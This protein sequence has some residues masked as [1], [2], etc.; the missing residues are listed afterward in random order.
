MI[1]LEAAR[2]R[3]LRVIC[4]AHAVRVAVADG[5]G[6][7]IRQPISAPIDLPPFDNS[8]MDGYA[9]LANDVR[10][11]SPSQPVRLRLRDRVPAGELPHAPV[12][13]GTCARV[14]TGSPLPPGADAVVMQEDTR[15]QPSTE[16]LLVLEP[17]KPWE[18]VRLR[19]EDLRCG[20]EVAKPGTRLTVGLAGLLAAL[21]IHQI[22]L[23]EQPALALL[24]TGS[25]LAEPGTALAPGKIY[26]SNRAALSLLAKTA[27]AIPRVY[28]IVPDTMEQTRAALERAL[29]ECHLLVTSG[30]VSVGEFDL[31]KEAF[32]SLGGQL[33]FWRVAIKPGKPFVFGQWKDKCLFALPGNPVSA[34]VTFLLLVRPALLKWQGAAELDLPSQAGILS[35]PLQN[36][37]DRRHFV[38]VRVDSEG[39]VQASGPQASHR[40]HS[41]ALANGLVDVPPNSTLPPGT[42]VTVLR[43]DLP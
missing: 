17:V 8:A 38:R 36:P 23:G 26:E 14:F 22:E 21:G 13:P 30:G 41:L 2:E 39:S 7:F 5:L 24:A 20:A 18:N 27:G 15:H 1:S 43:W 40:L 3:I 16:E 32:S 37:G 29:Q 6:R 9:L 31:V 4:P 10:S 34:T 19:G 28:P 11:A 12:T 25:E 33:D 42:K 35:S